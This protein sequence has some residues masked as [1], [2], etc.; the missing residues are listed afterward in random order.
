L[1]IEQH[2]YFSECI[3]EVTLIVWGV[4]WQIL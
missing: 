1:N 2:N 3:G 4:K